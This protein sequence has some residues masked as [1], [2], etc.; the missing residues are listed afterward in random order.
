MIDR[1]VLRAELRAALAELLTPEPER[2][3][4]EAYRPHRRKVAKLSEP[5]PKA[6]GGGT[7]YIGP[8]ACRDCGGGL[9]S[10]GDAMACARLRRRADPDALTSAVEGS[11]GVI[12]CGIYYE[13][14]A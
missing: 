5:I 14:P 7:R 3:P 8:D 2:S 11:G 12:E 1:E 4:I 10:L 9:V 6:E 13:D